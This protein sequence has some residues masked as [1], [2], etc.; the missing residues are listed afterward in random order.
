MF[1]FYKNAT[2]EDYGSNVKGLDFSVEGLGKYSSITHLDIKNP[3]V[4]AIKKANGE[5]PSISN[6]IIGLT[7]I[8]E[9]KLKILIG[10]EI[11]HNH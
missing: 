9:I 4:S 7:L 3:V 11:F 10:M 2:R 6:K 1:D 5:S 8:S